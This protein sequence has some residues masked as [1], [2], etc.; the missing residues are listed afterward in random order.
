[1]IHE[2][3]IFG[4]IIATTPLLLV[5]LWWSRMKLDKYLIR[6]I[7]IEDHREDLQRCVSIIITLCRIIEASKNRSYDD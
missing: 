2:L 5:A 7:N 1:M 4:F 3:L 6:P